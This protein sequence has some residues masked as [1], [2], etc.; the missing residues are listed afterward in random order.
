MTEP[1]DGRT[2]TWAFIVYPESAPDDWRDIVANEHVPALISPLH[3][4]DINAD[5][6]PKKPHWHVLLMY[7]GKKA[8][9]KI[10]ELTNSLNA[11]KPQPVSDK[12]G[13][14]RY[15][16]HADNPEK[17]QYDPKDVVQL[18][19]AD[20][21]QFLLGAADTDA[22]LGEMMDW[23][24]EQGCYSF[25]RLSM[26]A[27]KSRPDW[28]RVITSCRTVFLVNWLKSMHWEIQQ[29]ETIE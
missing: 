3:D 1:K 20:Y 27:R 12:R 15:L 11:P 23:C 26:Y 6:E 10:Q 28:F 24:V 14:A 18:G 21:T 19:G 16:I 29:G 2:R 13:Y 9:S 5:G 7:N 17:Y 4:K 22:A 8:R 25:Y